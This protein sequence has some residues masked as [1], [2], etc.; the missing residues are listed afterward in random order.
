MRHRESEL[1]PS[2]D[3]AGY[4]G[5]FDL[6]TGHRFRGG[7]EPVATP[8]PEPWKRGHPLAMAGTAG[9]AVLGV[10]LLIAGASQMVQRN[11][12]NGLAVPGSNTIA[13]HEAAMPPGVLHTP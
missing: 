4:G 11:E 8:A 9:V 2:F 7:F 6:E 10:A 3:A 13:A 12:I 1:G 5:G